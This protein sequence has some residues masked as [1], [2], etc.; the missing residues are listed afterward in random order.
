MGTENQKH[1]PLSNTFNMGKVVLDGEKG[2][3]QAKT[4]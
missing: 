1:E 2:D 4:H 3:G